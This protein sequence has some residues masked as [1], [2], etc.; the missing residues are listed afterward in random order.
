MDD[1]HRLVIP[2]R[3]RARPDTIAPATGSA[4]LS[5]RAAAPVGDA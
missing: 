3:G 4:A 1:D 2:L 5:V